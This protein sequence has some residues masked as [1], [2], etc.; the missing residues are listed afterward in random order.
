MHFHRSRVQ[1]ESLD[2]D[3]QNLLLLQLGK[4][5]IQDAFLGPAIHAHIAT[6]PIAV[7]LGQSAPLTS[8][9]GH[10]EDRVQQDQILVAHIAALHRQAILNSLILLGSNLHV[11]HLTRD[12]LI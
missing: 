2:L 3:A 9:L 12:L 4:H 10:V 7:P 5:L 6:V 11:M 1:T 8:V